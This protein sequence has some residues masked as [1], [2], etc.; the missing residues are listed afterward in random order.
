MHQTGDSHLIS[1]GG[2]DQ[3][4]DGCKYLIVNPARIEANYLPT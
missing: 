2:Q 3:R 1:V 4:V